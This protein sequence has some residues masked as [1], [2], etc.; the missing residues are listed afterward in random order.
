MAYDARG[1]EVAG[2]LP[3]DRPHVFKAQGGYIFPWGTSIAANYFAQSGALESTT[4][5]QRG[6]DAFING[7]GD[8]GRVDT[9]S[10]VD[11]RLQHDIRLFGDHR[12][13]FAIDVWNVF[14]QRAVVDIGHTPYRDAF[15]IPDSVYF[16]AS[17]FDVA[18]YVAGIRAA[19]ND[20]LGRTTLRANPFYGQ[21]EGT[22]A[23]Q[24]RRMFQFSAKYRF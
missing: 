23:Y 3:H 8:L 11:L 16:A 9:L 18:S 4:I 14:D 21:P 10:Q 22:S 15:T 6:R 17:G 13:N 12:L 19:A 2:R 20:P 1:T 24:T 5:F 7:R